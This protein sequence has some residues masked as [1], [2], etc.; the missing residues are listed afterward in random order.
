VP[1]Y[2]CYIAPLVVVLMAALMATRSHISRAG[3]AVVLAFYVLAGIALVDPGSIYS[4]GYE[5]ERPSYD[6][7]LN[8]TGAQRLRVLPFQSALYNPMIRVVQEHA[9]GEYV[10][11]SPSAPEVYFLSGHRN[12]THWTFDFFDHHSTD[13]AFIS[14]MLSRYDIN[15][16]VV[17]TKP[18]FDPAPTA[19]M[20]AMYARMY[21]Q[22]QT[23]AKF[24]VRWRE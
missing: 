13:V 8:A 23:F 4:L 22:S 12:P 19:E 6:G 16:I 17:N 2:F 3:V 10:Y 18:D 5:Y 11:A 15:V 21:P 9:R 7:R 24:Q 1:V 14:A 20:M